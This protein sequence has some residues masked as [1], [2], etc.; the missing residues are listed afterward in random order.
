MISRS[1]VTPPLYA[2]TRSVTDAHAPWHHAPWPLL[3]LR[4]GHAPWPLLTLRATTL[5]ERTT[6]H[7]EM[8]LP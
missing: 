1:V 8:T 3:T 4:D 2:F 6:T 7:S 5:R